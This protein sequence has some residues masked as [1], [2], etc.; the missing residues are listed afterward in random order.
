MKKRLLSLVLAVVMILSLLPS[1][2]FAAEGDAADETVLD[3]PVVE[4]ADPEDKNEPGEIP[5]EGDT[6]E[7][8]E[9]EAPEESQEPEETEVPEETKEPE[10]TEAPEETEE[11]EV[12]GEEGDPDEAVPPVI[13]EELLEEEIALMSLEPRALADIEATEGDIAAT[14]LGN[15]VRPLPSEGVT[16]TATAD[17]QEVAAVP[18]SGAI[19]GGFTGNNRWSSAVSSNPPG[20]RSIWEPRGLFP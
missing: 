1:A 9:T 19:D 4:V 10:E 11:P 3:G 16:V 2:A 5:N 8:E 20:F 17:S 12:P 13:G 18:A 6:Q 7:P 14:P 15:L